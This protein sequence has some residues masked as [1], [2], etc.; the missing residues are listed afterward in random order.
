MSQ[1][2][3]RGP[4]L[5]PRRVPGSAVHPCAGLPSNVPVPGLCHCRCLCPGL[6]TAR[7]AAGAARPQVTRLPFRVGLD[8]D[9]TGEDVPEHKGLSE[10][11]QAVG[12]VLSLLLVALTGCLL[13]LLLYKK[14]RR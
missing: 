9:G 11:S 10:R 13:T 7:V 12:A 8:G 3:G 6:G 4:L 14:E 5:P 2:C 1:D